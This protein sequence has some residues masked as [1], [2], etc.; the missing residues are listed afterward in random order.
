MSGQQDAAGASEF[1][2]V[3]TL[4]GERLGRVRAAEV[5]FGVPVAKRAPGPYP[6]SVEAVAGKA[7][8]RREIRLTVKGQ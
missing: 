6:L 3:E 2:S 8:K 4:G 7:T 1:A 5:R